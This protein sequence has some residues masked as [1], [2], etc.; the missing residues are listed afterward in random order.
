[1][2]TIMSLHNVLCLGWFRYFATFPK[3]MSSR[4]SSIEMMHYNHDSLVIIRYTNCIVNCCIG[5]SEMVFGHRKASCIRVKKTIVATLI[6]AESFNCRP[7]NG[8]GT[9]FETHYTLTPIFF[10]LII[11]LSN[12][13]FFKFFNV[14]EHHIFKF[15]KLCILLKDFLV[16][17]LTSV[18]TPIFNPTLFSTFLKL[19]LIYFFQKFSQ[20]V[21]QILK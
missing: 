11:S 12:P 20:I 6:H 15:L 4:L 21:F 7:K 5:V 14:L 1:M 10:N 18:L 3:A 16:A 17:I 2:T 19:L 8:T 9:Y 13:D